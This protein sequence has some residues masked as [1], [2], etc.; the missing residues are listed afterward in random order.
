[1]SAPDPAQ[2]AETGAHDPICEAWQKTAGRP[3]TCGALS[4]DTRALVRL[5]QEVEKQYKVW[6][7]TGPQGEVDW[8]AGYKA[9]LAW[10]R[11][12]IDGALY[13]DGSSDEA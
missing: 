4:A 11:L 9:A 13:F 1:M 2:N 3:C 12:R 10:V 8:K 7:L 6:D 5:R